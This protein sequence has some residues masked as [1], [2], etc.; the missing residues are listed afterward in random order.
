MCAEYYVHDV[1]SA[2]QLSVQV[3]LS[4]AVG[5]GGGGGG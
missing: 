1:A 3:L 5:G 2:V 4:N